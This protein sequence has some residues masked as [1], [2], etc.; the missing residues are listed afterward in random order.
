MKDQ[1]YANVSTDHNIH[2]YDEKRGRKNQETVREM[3][4][5]QW[6]L[7]EKSVLMQWDVS[8]QKVTTYFETVS[9]HFFSNQGILYGTASC[10]PWGG[11][12]QRALNHVFYIFKGIQCIFTIGLEHVFSTGRAASRELN[13]VLSTKGTS[14]RAGF[15]WTWWK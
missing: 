2:T 10:F 6:N 13:L 8:T 1:K 11:T 5:H 15:P 14:K 3:F 12:P 7:R 4:M 9:S